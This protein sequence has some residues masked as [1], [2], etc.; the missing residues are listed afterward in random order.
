VGLCES[1]LEKD[2]SLIQEKGAETLVMKDEE[3]T[4]E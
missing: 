4:D 2:P 3:E 1:C